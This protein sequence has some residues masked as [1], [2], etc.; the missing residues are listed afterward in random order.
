MTNK[1]PSRHLK[2]LIGQLK[3]RNP[4]ISTSIIA[5]K[6]GVSQP[7]LSLI[8][9]GKRSL[10]LETALLI[11]RGLK[12]DRSETLDFLAEI[13]PYFG[14]IKKLDIPPKRDAFKEIYR[15]AEFQSVT[16]EFDLDW[17]EVFI[18][19]LTQ[20]IGFRPDI[21]W[22]SKR[23]GFSKI[24]VQTAIES[25]I[26]KK[27]LVESGNSFEKSKLKMNF[28]VNKSNP[29]IKRY[30]QAMAIAAKEEL[31]KSDTK[32]VEN[33]WISSMTLAG[34]PEKI[35]TIKE[36]LLSINE[37]VTE[38]LGR[39]KPKELIQFNVQVFPITKI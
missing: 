38:R 19:D 15:S 26:E 37:S 6:C 39:S 17:K 11:A 30:H 27:Y 16:C 20:T 33:R 12:L 9:A 18:L 3:K 36:L 1:A 24:S 34:D 10:T 7:L 29:K 4:N 25:L 5:K 35:A 31:E 22:I 13:D 8:L 23:L 2:R 14:S 32:S 21:S 28:I